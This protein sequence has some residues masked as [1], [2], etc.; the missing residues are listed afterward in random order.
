MTLPDRLTA[1]WKARGACARDD[2]D[3]ALWY[4]ESGDYRSAEVAKAICAICP[5]RDLCLAD[6]ILRREEHGIWHS[7]HRERQRLRRLA[8]Q[9]P[10]PVTTSP[11]PD[12][13]TAKCLP[14]GAA[15]ARQAS[16]QTKR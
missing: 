9:A 13:V 2:A 10:E 12:P 4:P 14:S 16:G 3:P 6:A 7:S 1:P 15:G 8:R 5:V 11:S